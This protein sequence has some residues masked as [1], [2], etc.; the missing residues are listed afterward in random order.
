[1][2]CHEIHELLPLHLYGDLELNER[3]AVEEHL[4]A[5]PE[6]RAELA[7]LGG[8]RRALDVTPAEFCHVDVASIYRAE[9]DRLH[10][11][12][13]RWRAAAVLTAIAAVLLLALRVE[14]RAD[15]RQL[16]VRWGNPEVVAI[17][18]PAVERVVVRTEPS[19]THEL[20]ERINRV[21]ALIQA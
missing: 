21:S 8:V 20:E 12:S 10:R 6:C 16:I 11:R 18:A 9:S 15:G 5:C 17:A 19:A 2:K 13:R 1:M 14:V 3:S 7:A 4:S